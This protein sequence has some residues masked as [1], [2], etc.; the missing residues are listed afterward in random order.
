MWVFLLKIDYVMLLN[1]EVGKGNFLGWYL[2][3]Q[4]KW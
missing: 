4:I 3:F 2:K 1:G